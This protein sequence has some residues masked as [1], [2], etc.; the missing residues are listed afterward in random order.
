MKLPLVLNITCCL[1]NGR[2][3]AHTLFPFIKNR[4]AGWLFFCPQVTLPASSLALHFFNT[5]RCPLSS[6]TALLSHLLLPRPL[7]S[8]LQPPGSLWPPELH[9]CHC[10]S[11]L[12]LLFSASPCLTNSHHHP[13]PSRKQLCH[14][15]LRVFFDFWL[16]PLY[17]GGGKASLKENNH[18]PSSG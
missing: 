4:G 1:P 18:I 11:S 16:L 14:I 8:S 10:K 5:R 13:N 15:L 6:V 9:L 2:A 3:S 17:K 7:P 12:S